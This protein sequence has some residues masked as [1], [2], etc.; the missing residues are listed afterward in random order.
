M[1]HTGDTFFNGLYPFIDLESG[2]SIDGMI[3]A[4]DTV[5]AM[6]DGET[7][8]IPGHGPLASRDDLA[9]YRN[10]LSTI[11]DRVAAMIADG[12]ALEA[13][14]AAKPSAEFDD[15]ANRFGFLTPDQFVAT[16]YRSLGGPE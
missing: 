16:V 9:A 11:R 5:L 13:V 14:Q 10:A 15:T 7:A 1:I 3:A 6:A 4:A 2:G 12:K 8:I